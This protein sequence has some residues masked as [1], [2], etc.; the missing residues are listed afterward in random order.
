[1]GEDE[2]LQLS[3]RQLDDYRTCPLKYKYVHRLRVPLLTHHRIVY[4]A[5]MHKAIQEHFKARLAGAPFSEAQLIAAFR[6]AW[7]SEG[8]LSREHEEERLREGESTLRRF[9]AEDAAS[10]L[11]PTGVE[12]DFAFY[13]GR[14]RV[15]GRFDLVVENGSRVTIL[16]FKTGAVEDPAEAE[17]RAR[18]SLQLD[19]YALAHLR[20]SGRLPEWVELRFLESGLRGGKRPS[21]EQAAATEAV[22]REAAESIR[23][24]RF[25]AQPSYRA[26]AGCPFREI[27]PHT[28]RGTD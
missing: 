4:G 14:N 17:R 18:E 3:F 20:T 22:I 16:D 1:M 25:A 19:V 21:H 27:C 26:C 12:Q 7:V 23:Q 5:A 13:L 24:R 28:A 15:Q 10:P 9:H 6:A 8:F 2:T 11:L